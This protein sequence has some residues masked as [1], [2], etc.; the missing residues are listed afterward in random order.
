MNDHGQETKQR[1]LWTLVAFS[2][3]GIGLL[4]LQLPHI[5]SADHAYSR[6][7][8]GWF[9]PLFLHLN[10]LI[11]AAA[12]LLPPFLAM[13]YVCIMREEK[14][15]RLK[16]E[17]GDE[18]W[19]QRQI[20][21]YMRMQFA[22]ANYAV[23]VLA[24]MVIVA[25]GGTI[26]LLVKP[27]LPG[28]GEN[29]LFFKDGANILLL[30]ALGEEFKD[31]AH[32]ILHALTA[33]GF[34]FLGA[35]AYSISHLVRAY[36]T[37]DL[38]PN[39]FVAASV[40]MIVACTLTLVFS[41]AFTFVLGET[42]PGVVHHDEASVAIL[43]VLGFFFGYFPKKALLGIE[44]LVGRLF[45][46]LL[47]ESE[48]ESLALNRI[49]GMNLEH[50]SRLEREGI[51][52]VEN[53]ALAEPIEIAIRTGFSYRQVETWI[54]EAWL[55]AHLGNADYPKLAKGCGILTRRQLQDIVERWQPRERVFEQL[56]AASKVAAAK[57]EF[58]YLHSQDDA[59]PQ[60]LSNTAAPI[61]P[62]LEIRRQSSPGWQPT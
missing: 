48:S 52:N 40:R 57:L 19:E 15:R 22:P 47:R 51:D 29:G 45:G 43:P 54:E 38:T 12:V 4:S 8:N 27:M 50:A 46:K 21:E 3:A 6:M 14:E 55:R 18:R 56:A 25:F 44:R 30:G 42:D 37:V 61:A 28:M 17:I 39:T 20:R 5:L 49:N 16:S 2:A 41:F 58:V 35:Y 23:S 31:H 10:V 59:G 9:D 36:F 11:L 60:K 33:I 34:G 26:L 53:L 1:Y 62:R 32:I 13:T 24:M 7:H